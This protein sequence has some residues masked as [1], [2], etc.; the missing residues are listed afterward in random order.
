MKREPV[1]MEQLN[2]GRFL[3]EKAMEE[4]IHKHEAGE[5]ASLAE[6]LGCIERQLFQLRGLWGTNP[7][8]LKRQLAQIG[9]LAQFGIASICSWNHEA[10]NDQLVT[11]NEFCSRSNLSVGEVNYLKQRIAELEGAIDAS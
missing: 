8:E 10:C 9:Q 7:N 11:K 2:H 5:F 1:T 4:A 3:V 6:I